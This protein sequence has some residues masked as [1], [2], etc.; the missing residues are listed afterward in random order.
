MNQS[1]HTAQ[2]T[3][4][5]KQPFPEFATLTHPDGV[6]KQLSLALSQFLRKIVAAIAIRFEFFYVHLGL[7]PCQMVFILSEIFRNQIGSLYGN[8]SVF[9][10][11]FGAYEGFAEEL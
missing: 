1:A 2:P 6:E 7:T 5:V 9:L 3:L 4:V 11:F 10:L 8:L